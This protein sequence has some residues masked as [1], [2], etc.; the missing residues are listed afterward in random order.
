MLLSG[1]IFSLTSVML[2]AFAAHGLK[3]RLGEYAIGIFETAAQYQMAHGIG[4]VLCGLYAY[5][6]VQGPTG[7]AGA[8]LVWLKSSAICFTLGILFFSGSLYALAITSQKWLGPI[9]PLGGLL[10]ITGWVCFIVAVIKN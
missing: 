1:A 8:N 3:S 5:Q 2:G 4:L 6:L 9:T 7:L 10:L